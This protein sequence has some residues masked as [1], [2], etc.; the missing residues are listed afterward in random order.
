MCAFA[1]INMLVWWIS[2]TGDSHGEQKKGRGGVG[3]KRKKNIINFFQLLDL[4]HS[5][6]PDDL[7]RVDVAWCATDPRS[8][9]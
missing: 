4:K 6:D 7:V 1:K 3:G 8:P 2:S 9:C 5:C